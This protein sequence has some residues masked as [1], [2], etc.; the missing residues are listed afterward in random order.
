[1]DDH[2]YE[3]VFNYAKCELIPR[4]QEE[5]L[6]YKKITKCPSYLEIKDLCTVL[7]IVSKYSGHNHLVPL[8]F[9]D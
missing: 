9:I 3:D 8:N 5:Y 7:N 4:F 6:E 1:M 2:M